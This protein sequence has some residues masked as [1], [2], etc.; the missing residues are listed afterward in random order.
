MSKRRR[1][2]IALGTGL[3]GLGTLADYYYA[4]MLLRSY[5][6]LF[7]ALHLGPVEGSQTVLGRVLP[8]VGW[9][10]LAGSAAL[11]VGPELKQRFR[12]TRQTT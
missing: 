12:R 4:L 6:G 5:V 7:E 9:L 11:F 1:R 3:I 10:F 8:F 2:L